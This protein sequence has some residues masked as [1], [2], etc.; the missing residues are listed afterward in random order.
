MRG[1][2]AKAEPSNRAGT[3]GA[4]SGDSVGSGDGIHRGDDTLYWTTILFEAWTFVV[5]AT[6]RGLMYVDIDPVASSAAIAGKGAGTAVSAAV[7]AAL[8]NFGDSEGRKT[9]DSEIVRP[10]AAQIE[11]YLRGELDRFDMPLDL[12]GTPFQR[13]VWEALLAV[14]HGRTTSY[15]SIAETIGRPRAVRA[16]GAAVGAN[17]LL[18][19]V[20]CHR[21]VGKNGALTGFR[22]GLA[23]KERLLRMESAETPFIL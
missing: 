23:L 2:A 21:V 8:P 6:A 4:V 11:A 18:L 22:A 13:D 9:Y 12:R 19:V 10:F 14:P 1:N 20:P 15:S 16:V 7:A 17:P 3:V 5:A